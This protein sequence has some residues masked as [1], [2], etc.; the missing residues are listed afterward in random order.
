M[1]ISD[2]PNFIDLLDEKNSKII[3]KTIVSITAGPAAKDIGKI[4]NN[5]TIKLSNFVL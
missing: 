3:K 2:F 1:I 5:K 4:D